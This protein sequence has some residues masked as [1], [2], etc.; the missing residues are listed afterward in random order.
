MQDKNEWLKE[1]EA[2]RPALKVANANSDPSS[3]VIDESD[4]YTICMLLETTPE[5]IRDR[6]RSRV[7]KNVN[8][9]HKSR[10]GHQK[11]TLPDLAKRVV[12]QRKPSNQQNHGRGKA[13]RRHSSRTMKN[14]YMNELHFLKINQN[15]PIQ[16]CDMSGI[17]KSRLARLT[18][19]ILL[20]GG[21]EWTYQLHNYLTREKH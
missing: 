4:I 13:G 1:V 12:P 8:D 6:I 21:G 20:Q 9:A 7:L 5:S 2:V 16:E 11:L 17:D 14:K 18:S 19:R 3:P 15:K 10:D